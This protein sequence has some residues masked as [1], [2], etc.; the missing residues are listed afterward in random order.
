[1]SVFNSTF[2][3]IT[4]NLDDLFGF[5]VQQLVQGFEHDFKL[6][7]GLG[8]EIF[9]LFAQLGIVDDELPEPGEGPHDLDV[10][11][12]CFFTAQDAGH[13]GYALLGKGM[14]FF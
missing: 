2:S 12:D 10:D 14:N 6:V 3:Q 5:L 1:M 4:V 8:A 7:F 11:L 9:E 13:H